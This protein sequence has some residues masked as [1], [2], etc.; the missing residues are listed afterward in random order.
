MTDVLHLGGIAARV[1]SF[2]AALRLLALAACAM[3]C[4]RLMYVPI[5]VPDMLSYAEAPA[6]YRLALAR[7][8][9]GTAFQMLMVALGWQLYTITNSAFD[10]GLVGLVSFVPMLISSPFAGL[11]ADAVDRRRIAAIT[12][13]ASA[14]LVAFLALGTYGGWTERGHIL[15]S[16]AVLGMVRAFEFP[17]ISALVPLTV[18]R[19]DLA[20]A[21]AMYSSANQIAVIL[22]PALGGLLYWLGPAMP[23][24][25]S[26]LFFATSCLAVMGVATLTAQVRRSEKITLDTL[27]AGFNYIRRTPELLGTMSLDL[28][29]FGLGSG[30]ALLPIVAKDILQVGPLGLGMLRAAPAIGAVVMTLWLARFPVRHKAGLKMFCSVA[31]FG[32][33]S[34]A[35]GLSE[36]VVVSFLALAVFGAVD[37]VSVIIRQS[38]VQMRTPDDMRGRVGAVNSMFIATSNQL[39]D[40]RAGTA[41]ALLGTGPAIVLGGVTA[42]VVTMAWMRLFPSIVRLERPE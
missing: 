19:A 2:A 38:L 40:F 10:L 12:T 16:V 23:Y 35:F 4:L 22:G 5:R 24:A 21:T 3:R 7:F 29:A 36:N 41:A 20:R 42:L 14:V 25:I 11:T 1:F 32:L 27:A 17:A 15:A 33:T 28:V 9:S 6:F 37:A 31:G 30:L 34:I 8:L 13:A 39:G 18:H 26:V